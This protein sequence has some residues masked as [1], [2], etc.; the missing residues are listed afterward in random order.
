[1]Y[2]HLQKLNQIYVHSL[3]TNILVGSVKQTDFKSFPITS[4][5][6]IAYST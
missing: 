3:F 1:M 5:K 4:Q 6:I 2:I